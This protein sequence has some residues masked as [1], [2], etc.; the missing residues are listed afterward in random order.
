MTREYI[1]ALFVMILAAGLV[2]ATAPAGDEFA[3]FSSSD[4]QELPDVHGEIVVWQQF[5]EEYGDYDV[6]IA[7]INNPDDPNLIIIGDANDQMAPAVFEN[8]VV[9]QDDIFWEGSFDWDIRMV[10]ITD[11]NAPELFIVS[12]I[13]ENDEQNPAIHGNIVVWQDGAEGSLDVYGADITDPYYPMEFVVSYADQNQLSPAIHRS[14]VVWQDDY[15]GDEDIFS[16]D[17]WQRN[18]PVESAVSWYEGNQGNPAVF[19]RT[20][21]WQ[22]DYFGDWDIFAADISDPANPDEFTITAETSSQ[23]NPDIDGNIVVWQDDRDGDWDIFAYNLTTHREFRITNDPNDQI[24]P[25]ISGNLVVW[26]DNRDGPQNIY[27]VRLKGPIMAQC[28]RKMPGDINEDCRIDFDDFSLLAAAWLQCNFDQ[29]QLCEPK[30]HDT[31]AA[32]YSALAKAREAS[33]P[34]TELPRERQSVPLRGEYPTRF[35]KY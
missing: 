7:D 34:K 4:D 1:S 26:Q 9:Y 29:P 18:R 33:I 23:E 35:R 31:K 13:L 32:K 16:A 30:L 27:A 10:D 2:P 20:V 25:A 11:R 8:K 17:I 6:Y 15:F 3:I 22:D 19:G 21:V 28:R 14:T 5:V 24:N 12:D